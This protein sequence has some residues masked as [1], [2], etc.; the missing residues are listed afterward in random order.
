[1]SGTTTISTALMTGVTLSAQCTTLT[2]TGSISSAG[3]AAVY[4]PNST[5][6]TLVNSGQITDSDGTG[7]GVSLAAGGSVNN[8]A[9]VGAGGTGVYANGA[10][11]TVSNSG[12]ISAVNEVA[13]ALLD[14]GTVSNATAPR[15]PAAPRALPW[16]GLDASPI[17]D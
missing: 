10:T 9:S 6:N 3:A 1:V 2:A 16:T 15:S 12:T 17:T 14:G 7:F 5:D 4:V 11:A 8:V 13:V